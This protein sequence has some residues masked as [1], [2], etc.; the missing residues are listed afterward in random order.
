MSFIIKLKQDHTT[1]CNE[2]L[3]EVDLLRAYLAGLKQHLMDEKERFRSEV[4][5]VV[6]YEVEECSHV[7]SFFRGIDDQTWDLEHIFTQHFP[8]LLL[9]S[10]FVSFYS[11]AEVT[12][13]TL[14]DR[15]TRH[16]ESNVSVAD[17]KDKGISRAKRY[18]TKLCGLDFGSLPP[19]AE[20]KNIAEVRNL[21]VHADGCVNTNTR[22]ELLVV[23]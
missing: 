9:R 12:L 7:V 4:E 19:W 16:M 8:N 23:H 10:A 3:D 15:F 22:S 1:W 2:A 18:L 17:M 20:L 14:C 11:F 6:L 21:I 13:D 5:E